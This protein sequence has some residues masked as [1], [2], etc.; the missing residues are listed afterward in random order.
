MKHYWPKTMMENDVETWCQSMSSRIDIFDSD[1]LQRTLL[2][3]AWTPQNETGWLTAMMSG[4]KA[5]HKW[6][7]LGCN[8]CGG[9]DCFP[10]HGKCGSVEFNEWLAQACGSTVAGVLQSS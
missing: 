4:K 7:A 3:L 5:R 6:T 2:M 9:C 8:V 1:K 10:L